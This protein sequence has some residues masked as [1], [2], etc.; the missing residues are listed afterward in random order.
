MVVHVSEDEMIAVV[1]DDRLLDEMVEHCRRAGRHET[2]GILIGRYSELRDQAVV[3]QV[4]GPPSD[5]RAGRRWFVRGVRGLDRVLAR[6]WCSH[7]YYLGEWHYHPFASAAASETDR[8]QTVAFAREPAYWCPQ[9]ILLIIGGDPAVGAQLEASVVL[10]GELRQL[11][12]APQPSGSPR[13]IM[14]DPPGMMIGGRRRRR[15]PWN[16]GLG[17]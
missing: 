5:S 4:T 10:D 9:P 13:T 2:G 12:P 11:A 17:P 6:A 14:G 1:L 7:D 15:P 8:Q 16:R 3:T